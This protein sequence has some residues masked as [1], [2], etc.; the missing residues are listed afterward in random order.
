[1]LMPYS[2]TKEPKVER[3]FSFAPPGS[4]DLN[5]VVK[6]A[7]RFLDGSVAVLQE[8]GCVYDSSRLSGSGRDALG[9][10]VGFDRPFG[11]LF[12][13]AL[14]RGVSAI[15][16]VTP[17]PSTPDDVDAAKAAAGQGR[18]PELAEVAARCQTVWE[19][20]GELAAEFPKTSLPPAAPALL[21]MC[22]VLSATGLGPILL[23]DGSL[24]DAPGAWERVRELSKPA[25]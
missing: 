3:I 6:S 25:A 12:R 17:R 16:R 5:S 8:A 2:A 18:K 20:V 24:L 13:I 4:L 1:M 14:G 19:V 9:T 11:A 15:L 22:A 10:S 21:A 23:E 7:Y